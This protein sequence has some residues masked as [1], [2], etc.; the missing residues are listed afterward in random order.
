MALK[1]ALV[2]ELLGAGVEPAPEPVGLTRLVGEERA[3]VG[4]WVRGGTLDGYAVVA[5][6]RGGPASPLQARKSWFCLDEY[7]VALG[8]GITA[9]SGYAVETIV[10]DRDLP[11]D[12]AGQ[13]LVDGVARASELSESATVRAARWA[14]LE[15][16]GGYVFPGRAR[17]QLRREARTGSWPA[18]DQIGSTTRSH[19]T[20]RIDHGLGPSSASYGYLV[21]PG[22]GARRTAVLAFSPS[23]RILRN[24]AA[25]Q[26]IG[27]RDLTM[28]SF[29]QSGTLDGI[30]V[31][32][33]CSLIQRRRDHTLELAVSDPAQIFT[34]VRVRVTGARKAAQLDE[35]VTIRR[36]WGYVELTVELGGSARTSRRAVLTC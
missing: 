20:M 18:V 13:V 33:P 16:V 7:A 9:P 3:S 22:A 27:W 29:W 12:G 30:T 21:A 34:S 36:R 31:D 4:T 17:L 8:A 5:Q 15:G 28:V 2:K 23:V 19:L 35:G 24:T 10:D 32:A 6:R 25:A 14:H 26:G 1:H 11:A